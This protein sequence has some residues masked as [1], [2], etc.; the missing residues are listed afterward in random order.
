M[1]AMPEFE[2]IGLRSKKKRTKNKRK[3]KKK[4]IEEKKGNIH[5]KLQISGSTHGQMVLSDGDISLLSSLDN[6]TYI[7]CSL[8][9]FGCMQ[10]LFLFSFFSNKSE[11][12]SF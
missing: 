1:F 7:N 4:R 11:L 12:R 3:F 6:S 2:S 9:S 5:T 8:N 10:T